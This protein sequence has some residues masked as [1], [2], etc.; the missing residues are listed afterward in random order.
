[1]TPDGGY[2]VDYRQSKRDNAGDLHLYLL[3]TQDARGSMP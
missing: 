1:M 2:C 3:F